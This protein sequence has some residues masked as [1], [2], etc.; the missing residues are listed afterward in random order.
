M[1]SSTSIFH[2]LLPWAAL[3]LIHHANPLC[4]HTTDPYLQ[5]IFH[6]L[7]FISIGSSALT[8]IKLIID[9]LFTFFCL[10]RSSSNQHSVHHAVFTQFTFDTTMH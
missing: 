10:W 5:V 3:R 4:T 7:V 6:F 8:I 2:H 9:F 1:T